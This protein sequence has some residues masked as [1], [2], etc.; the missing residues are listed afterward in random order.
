VFNLYELLKKYNIE[1]RYA[2]E[3]YRLENN[4]VVKIK[5]ESD[6]LYPF[7]E[8]D[9]FQFVSYS[10]YRP[11]MDLH[12]QNIS[13]Q[14]RDSFKPRL[15]GLTEKSGYEMYS[16]KVIQVIPLIKVIN[17]DDAHFNFDRLNFTLSGMPMFSELVVYMLQEIS[18]AKLSK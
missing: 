15:K 9:I 1:H 13:D 6:P 11:G 18:K 4:L 5:P 17:L 10:T 3:A 2:W 16:S 8:G 12:I 14:V 7:H